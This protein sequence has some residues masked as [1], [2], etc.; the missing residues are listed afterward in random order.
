M[1]PF[2]EKGVY[3]AVDV[4]TLVQEVM[5]SPLAHHNFVETVVDV[6]GRLGLTCTVRR[7]TLLDPPSHRAE[8]GT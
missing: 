7:S 5:V 1:T 6:V 4:P 2:G 3:V 8:A